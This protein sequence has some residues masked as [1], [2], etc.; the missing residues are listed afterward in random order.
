MEKSTKKISKSLA[1]VSVAAV[2]IISL[3]TSFIALNITSNNAVNTTL[4][5]KLT[6]ATDAVDSFESS[7]TRNTFLFT[8]ELYSKANIAASDITDKSTDEEIEK[9]ARYLYA[10]SIIVTDTEGKC[11]A[12][13]PADLKGT[14]IS[15]NED[16]SS[17]VKV[18]KGISFKSQSEPK[19]ADETTGEYSLYTAVG[20]PD[21]QGIAIIGTTV[22]D[23][24]Q[25]IGSDIAS[26][27]NDNTII[28]N[29][30][31][32]VSSS[33][34]DSDK[35]SLAEMGITEENIKSGTFTLDINGKEYTFKAQNTNNFTVL[36]AVSN[37]DTASQATTVLII[38][39]VADVIAFAIIAV[40][41]VILG[42]K[43][44]A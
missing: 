8:D 37:A 17:F 4:N 24:A 6:T 20:R 16:T 36:C 3:C 21:G 10:D 5:K 41:F 32:I 18:L 33:F 1:L 31:T 19:L 13:Y 27:C 29:G 39:L 30:D 34:A 38:T 40:L 42:K 43:K 15:D 11:I 9:L 26:D 44:S 23:Y 7:I 14:N 35:T 22:S 12:S 2:I 25:L 28:A